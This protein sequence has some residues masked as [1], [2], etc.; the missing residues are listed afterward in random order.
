MVNGKSDLKDVCIGFP[1]GSFPTGSFT[2]ARAILKMS[3]GVAQQN[4]AAQQAEYIY[5]KDVYR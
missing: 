4:R 2:M 1:T 5:L 3:M